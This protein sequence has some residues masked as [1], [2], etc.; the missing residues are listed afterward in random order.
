MRSLRRLRMWCA[1]VGAATLALAATSAAAYGAPGGPPPRSPASV[2]GGGSGPARA[3]ASR[4]TDP[5]HVLAASWRA[6]RDRAVAVSG[7]SDGLHVLVA[8]ASAAYQWRTAAT[9]S[10]PGYD[11]PQWIGQDCVTGSGRYA[12]VV[13]GP[14]DFANHSEAM[15]HGAFA[16]VV[17]L[18]TGTVRKLADTVSLAYYSPGCGVGD[19][20]VFSAVSARDTATTTRIDTVD[21]ATGA[22]RQSAVLTGQVTSPVP[23]RDGVAAVLGTSVI[24][25]GPDGKRST[26]TTETGVPFDLH[27]DGGGGLAME[28]PA[29]GGVRI[30]RFASGTTTLLG[31]ADSSGVRLQAS[32]GRVFVT[33][34]E[35]KRI[36]L[37]PVTADGWSEVDG[38]WDAIVST[39]GELVLDSVGGAGS[40]ASAGTSAPAPSGNQVAVTA[41]V[42][43]T[44]KH[45][46][47]TVD[48]GVAQSS[49][50]SSPSPALGAAAKPASPTAG[51]AAH[52][53][54]TAAAQAAAA[55][56]Y[57][58]TNADD[59]ANPATAPW[60]PVRGCSVARNDPGIQTY[61]ATAKQIE[62]AADLAVQ[63][64]LTISR[65]AN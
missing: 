18:E 40:G 48:A 15:D 11:T 19:A 20:V 60:D 31:T 38:S 35:S 4:V 17:D 7:D 14:W 43:A 3:A 1:F 56:A 2:T 42:T 22:V 36:D 28:V 39:R 6:S 13:Y 54:V 53:S 29:A 5:D 64:K 25:V 26:L 16:A 33:G 9:L 51:T 58:T 57:S 23:Y 47:F 59:G 12:A 63:G 37:R 65:P 62:W 45:A 30:R 24:A 44:G 10:E 34:S 55:T 8:D 21:A 27:P 46:S 49:S 32:G 50:G 61:Q 52:T 41:T